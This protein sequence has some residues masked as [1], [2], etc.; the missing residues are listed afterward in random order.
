LFREKHSSLFAVFLLFFFFSA[1]VKARSSAGVRD[2]A[3]HEIQSFSA[4]TR[5]LLFFGSDRDAL[6]QINLAILVALFQGVLGNG[7]ERLLHGRRS[8]LQD[9]SCNDHLKRCGCLKSS[10]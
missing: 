2:F 1:R 7:L 10:D 4:A 8:Q 9:V 3:S 6:W 5:F